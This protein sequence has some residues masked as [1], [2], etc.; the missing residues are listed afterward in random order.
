MCGTQ[1]CGAQQR[2]HSFNYQERRRAMPNE[3]KKASLDHPI[4]PILADRW[5]PY[6]YADRP[7]SEADLRSLFE[8]ARWAA[9]SYNEQPWS[10]LL[11]TKAQSDQFARVLSCLVEANQAWAK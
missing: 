3:L 4:Q 11:A 7:V 5:S 2:P 9:S 1:M 6:A 10:Y 8:A